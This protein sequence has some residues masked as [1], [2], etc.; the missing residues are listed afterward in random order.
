ML[1]DCEK[2]IKLTDIVQKCDKKH[3]QYEYHQLDRAVQTKKKREQRVICDGY[4]LTQSVDA[5]Y[6]KSIYGELHPKA[7]VDHP[8]GL[9]IASDG[10]N[11]KK[12]LDSL[13]HLVFT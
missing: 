2:T 8:F 12:A 1:L 13:W 9:M 4:S 10:S 11:M 6:V 3:M 7:K 5:D